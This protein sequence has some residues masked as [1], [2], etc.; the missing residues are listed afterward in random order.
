M[1]NIKV[2]NHT[3]F[4][5]LKILIINGKEYFPASGCATV[6]G[7]KTFGYENLTFPVTTF[8]LNIL[9]KINFSCTLE[10]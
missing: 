1:G 3:E 8:T 5:E 2:F 10:C 4:G 9:L 6:L 7:S